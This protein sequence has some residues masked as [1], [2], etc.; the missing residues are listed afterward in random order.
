VTW[1]PLGEA[2]AHNVRSDATLSKGENLITGMPQRVSW[3]IELSSARYQPYL[4]K[5]VPF[6]PCSHSW[7]V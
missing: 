6:S 7:I 1:A 4:M 3:S 5:H 2:E